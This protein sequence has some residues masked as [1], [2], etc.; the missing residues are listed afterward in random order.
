MTAVSKN[1]HFDVLDNIVHKYNNTY[2]HTIK[3]KPID[4]KSGP[5][6]EYGVDSNAKHAKF[7]ISDRVTISKYKI[8]FAKAFAPDWSEE[9]FVISKLKNNVPWTYVISD[10]NGEKIDRMFYEKVLQ[11]RNLAKY[12][13][14]KII[15]RKGDKLY[16]KWKGYDN[17][18]NSCIARS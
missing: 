3:M 14:E 7:K 11:K 8:I 2:H 15:K 12:R 4:V 1:V 9:A 10:L 18:F 13:V 16:V 5:D 6:A 17:S